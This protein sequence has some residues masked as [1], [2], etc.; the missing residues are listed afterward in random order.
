PQQQ[1]DGSIGDK[2]FHKT[3]PPPAGDKGGSSSDKGKDKTTGKSAGTRV[4]PCPADKPL[5]GKVVVTEVLK[6]YWCRGTNRTVLRFPLDCGRF[7]E[8][9]SW[10]SQ[11]AGHGFDSTEINYEISSDGCTGV[12]PQNTMHCE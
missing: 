7:C 2:G 9:S 12:T 3:S 8:G 6:D 11:L 10:N 5:G 4:K 1:R